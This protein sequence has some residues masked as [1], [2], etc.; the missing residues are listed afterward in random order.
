MRRASKAIAIPCLEVTY[1]VFYSHL[2]TTIIP[3]SACTKNP[4]Y[5]F[6]RKHL[7]PDP[8]HTQSNMSIEKKPKT[9]DSYDDASDIDLYSF[10]EQHAGRLI[11]D[12]AYI[13]PLLLNPSN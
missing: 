2:V 9:E 13:C 1:L 7:E 4:P 5:R 11:I 8:I 12:P 3:W 6:F 10:H